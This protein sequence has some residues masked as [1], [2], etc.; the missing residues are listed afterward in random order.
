VL[1]LDW[2]RA[3]NLPPFVSR[4]LV[5]E[6]LLDIFPEGTPARSW[7]VRD[8]AASTVFA[9]LYIGAVDGSGRFFAPRHVYRMNDAQAALTSD[10]SR[11]EYCIDAARRGYRPIGHPWYSDNTREPIRDETIRQGLIPLGAMADLRGLPTTS[12]KPRYFL[13]KDFVSLFDPNVSGNE[14][15]TL[16]AT[17][18]STHLSTSALHRVALVRAGAAQSPDDFIVTFPNRETRRLTPGPSSV[19]SKAVI[20]QFATKFL[21][22]PAVLLL[23]ESANKVVA[24]DE[25]LAK[26]IGLSLAADRVLPDIVL[27][28]LCE[29]ETLIVFVEVVHTDGPISDSRRDDLQSLAASA[30]FSPANTA[31]VTAYMDRTAPAFRRTIDTLAWNTFVFIASEPDSLIVLHRRPSGGGIRLHE[32]LA[33]GLMSR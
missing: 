30:G 26:R 10:A 32:I 31:F 21:A 1:S 22:N 27:V 20:E 25:V 5:S 16:M 2:N 29:P 11:I 14:L 33:A 15:Q 17:W 4:S 6:R 9:A 3:L 7:C 12:D 28:D 18:R 8:I 19:I 24:R 13:N 23:S